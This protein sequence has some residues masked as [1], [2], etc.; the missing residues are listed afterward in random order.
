MAATTTSV[1]R[2][3]TV[4]EGDRARIYI[5]REGDLA[6]YSTVWVT[7]VFSDRDES[8]G[9][10]SFRRVGGDGVS[11]FNQNQNQGAI[12]FAPGDDRAYVEFDI[13]EDG[14][15]EDYE[16]FGIEIL[17]PNQY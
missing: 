17:Q 11:W 15:A 6:T 10:L 5:E 8:W 2:S 12:N 13:T 1:D 16:S 7:V 14:Q 3:V 4:E 9:D